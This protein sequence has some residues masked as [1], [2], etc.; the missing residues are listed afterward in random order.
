MR[1]LP[2]SSLALRFIAL[3]I[4]ILVTTLGLST[5]YLI[6]RQYR[7]GE[8]QLEYKVASLGQF[9]ALIAPESLLAYDLTT[10]NDYVIEIS[11]H[12]EILFVLVTD[13]Q[14]NAL[15]TYID[16][17]MRLLTTTEQEHGSHE[18]IELL[19]QRLAAHPEAMQ[20]QFDIDFEQQKLGEITIFADKTPSQRQIQTGIYHYIL[21][22]LGSIILLGAAIYLVFRTQVIAPIRSLLLGMQR[23]A[24]GDLEHPVSIVTHDEMGELTIGFNR[25]MIHIR[26]E[27]EA[28]RKLSSAVEQSHASVIITNTAGTIEYVNPPF[29]KITGYSA[30]EVLGQNPRLLKSGK[31]IPKDLP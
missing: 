9:F 31:N 3:T 7:L 10:L 5:S 18:A 6:E 12:P 14:Q 25:M 8:Q 11:R 30:A 22:Y 23:V 24:N 13:S 29:S 4:L 17:T 20:L 28:L 19:Q 2:H 26:E 15:T 27:R 16:P 21:L 1:P